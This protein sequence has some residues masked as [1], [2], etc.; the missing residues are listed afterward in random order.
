MTRLGSQ[1]TA[2]FT[3]AA[4]LFSSAAVSFFSANDVGHMASSSRFASSLKPNVAYLALNLSAAWK[5]QTTLPSLAYAGHSVPGLRHQVG[6]AGR[7]DRMDALGEGAIRLR[8][9]GD[10][11]SRSRSP[12]ALFLFTRSSAFS[13]LARSFIAARSAS[14]NPL[15]VL[16]FC[17]GFLSATDSSL[18]VFTHS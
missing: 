11:A 4:I 13:S 15:D 12:S 3:S 7:D 14:V 5:K 6:R 16:P 18:S 1:L 17:A 8:H 2:F 10:L 9:L